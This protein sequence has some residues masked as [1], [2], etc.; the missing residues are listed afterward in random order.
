MLGSQPCAALGVLPGRG[1]VAGY[2]LEHSGEEPCEGLTERMTNLL[3]QS[4]RGFARSACGSQIAVQYERHGVKA[5]AARSGIVVAELRGQ[6]GVLRHL[7]QLSTRAGMLE[8]RQ[9]LAPLERCR[10]ERVM[11]LEQ[12]RAILSP[13]RDFQKPLADFL[14]IVQ[15]SVAPDV[16]PQSPKRSEKLPRRPDAV[17]QL[18]STPVYPLGRRGAKA[19]ARQQVRPERDIERDLTL[20][21][22]PRIRQPREQV[23]STS[24]MLDGYTRSPACARIVAGGMVVQNCACHI[25]SS[26][27]V[28]GKLGGALTCA[29]TEAALESIG[30]RDMQP[31]TTRGR[32]TFVQGCAVERMTK[33]KAAGGRPVRPGFAARGAHERPPSRELGAAGLHRLDVLAQ[34]G[35]DRRG[36]KLLACGTRDLENFA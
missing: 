21:P 32:Q 33:C 17:A 34:R 8:T 24:I 13:G 3:C 29:L 2:L 31:R 5:A 1:M 19:L 25:T 35:G 36:V 27:E 7:V 16:E 11:C 28:R 20:R 6:A 10:P 4:D 30:D 12:Q 15:M 14:G 23:Q 9:Q 18:L 22:L 26:L